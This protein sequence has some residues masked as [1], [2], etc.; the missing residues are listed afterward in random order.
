MQT[1]RWL[2][3]SNTSVMKTGGRE[4]SF[5]DPPGL[6]GPGENPLVGEVGKTANAPEL[7]RPSSPRSISAG[8]VAVGPVCPEPTCTHPGFPCR[9]GKLSAPTARLPLQEGDSRCIS[10]QVKA[11]TCSPLRENAFYRRQ[12]AT[13]SKSHSDKAEP[14]EEGHSH[15]GHSVLALP[16]IQASG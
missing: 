10:Q 11:I 14:F 16:G 6:E 4:P 8:F 1:T 3:S 13:G 2:C 5:A 15:T 9:R 12:V 7:E